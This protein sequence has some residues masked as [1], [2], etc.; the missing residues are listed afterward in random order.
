MSWLFTKLIYSTIKLL[1]VKANLELTQMRFVSAAKSS[2]YW[3]FLFLIQFSILLISICSTF[4]DANNVVDD[5]SHYLQQ[6]LKNSR[7]AKHQNKNPA[8]LGQMF[9]SWFDNRYRQTSEYTNLNDITYLVKYKKI[10]ANVLDQIE[11]VS[12]HKHINH[13]LMSA[14]I[15]FPFAFVG[16]FLSLCCNGRFLLQSLMLKFV[17]IFTWF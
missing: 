13:L 11:N 7:L 2:W 16:W 1:F 8:K 14:C 17:S 5:S 12:L 10:N 3:A 9:Q 6:K 4:R 15:C